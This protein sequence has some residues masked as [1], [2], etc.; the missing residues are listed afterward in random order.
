MWLPML[1]MFLLGGIKSEIPD[2][3][4]CPLNLEVL[5]PC[6]CGSPLLRGLKI[7]CPG[8]NL[9]LL[10]KRL[11]IL[12]KSHLAILEV[13]GG[14]I[15]KWDRFL[16]GNVTMLQ[17]IFRG[18]GMRIM[19]DRALSERN[20]AI[21]NKFAL[22]NNELEEVPNVVA[23]LRA[24]KILDMSFNR[25]KSFPASILQGLPLEEINLAGNQLTAI[26]PKAF[27]GLPAL[28]S[29]NLA[30]NKLTTVPDFGLPYQHGLKLLNMSGN[31][32][33]SIGPNE[34]RNLSYVTTLDL[35]QNQLN[36]LDDNVIRGTSRLQIL[37][38]DHNKF[39]ELPVGLFAMGMTLT[40]ISFAYNELQSLAPEI[41]GG[42]YYVQELKLDHNKFKS[43]PTGFI[44]NKF[45]LVTLDL[46][47]NP[48]TTLEEKALDGLKN[49]TFID[50]SHCSLTTIKSMG[51]G[52]LQGL[53]T[54]LL[55]DNELSRIDADGLGFLP[56]IQS[57]DLSRNRITSLRDLQIAK[58][59]GVMSL[60]LSHNHIQSARS[61]D[62]PKLSMLMDLDLSFNG[63]RDLSPGCFKDFLSLRSLKLHDNA[64]KFVDAGT[65]GT[66]N[67]LLELDMSNN[68]I[69]NFQRFA[70]RGLRAIRVIK[71]DNNFI[72]EFF[73]ITTTL[74]S[75]SLRN[76]SIRE[77]KRSSFPRANAL[78]IMDLSFNNISVIEPESF[79]FLYILQTLNL[80]G[81]HLTAIPKAELVNRVTLQNLDLGQN[82]ISTVDYDSFTGLRLRNLSLDR[83]RITSFN[84]TALKSLAELLEL[85]MGGNLLRQ[86]DPSMFKGMSSLN[87]LDMTGNLYGEISSD[88]FGELYSVRRISLS[89]NRLQ[90]FP[91]RIFERNAYLEEVDFSGNLMRVIPSHLDENPGHLRALNFSDNRLEEILGS[92]NLPYVEKLDL[93]HNSFQRLSLSALSK[94]TG[95]RELRLNDNPMEILSDASMTSN[96]EVL[97][98][99][100]TLLHVVPFSLLM[101]LNQDNSSLSFR[102]MSVQC[103]CRVAGLQEFLRLKQNTS[104]E[105]CAFPAA[106]EGVAIVNATLGTNCGVQLNSARN[107]LT[108]KQLLDLQAARAGDAIVL[109]WTSKEPVDIYSFSVT[110]KYENQSIQAPKQNIPYDVDSYAV[111]DLSYSKSYTACVQPFDTDR[112]RVGIASCKLVRLGS[113][114]VTGTSSVLQKND[115]RVFITVPY[116]GSTRREIIF[117]VES[118]L[119]PVCSV[120]DSAFLLVG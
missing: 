25:L 92:P 41:I 106:L 46:S 77:I 43:I 69:T 9:P 13:N 108:A 65:F 37:L 60:D 48:I 66:M 100:S 113:M 71:L 68:N 61:V 34:F 14:S 4:R 93:S 5:L 11:R 31:L 23:S 72:T 18:V 8:V 98:L 50:L 99:D 107:Y 35:S 10:S 45:H 76:N 56:S 82:D 116:I 87:M 1:F 112:K 51:I 109:R 115:F 3:P 89:R 111:E 79:K 90:S 80:R 15:R 88:A 97:S 21:I 101:A 94:L 70:L 118:Y 42:L 7:T 44:A 54:L 91:R 86:L 33:R 120:R 58:M 29:L 52:D 64:L 53:N 81:N 105:V 2:L 103:D 83:N 104:Q 67:G 84:E 28:I 17:V 40:N 19:E 49:I 96:L 62:M 27:A 38:M 75:A 78:S 32:L 110:V 74:G 30:F 85:R 12:G 26:S 47:W 36:T 6:R 22:P 39:T 20:I 73:Q 117:G 55:N 63:L 102:N 59:I 114:D 119:P 95:L 24:L 57:L 16:L